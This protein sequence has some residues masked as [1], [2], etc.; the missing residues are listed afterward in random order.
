MKGPLAEALQQAATYFGAKRTW[1]LVNG[2]C[3]WCARSTY[4][5][6]YIR[7]N[8]KHYH[9]ID[10]AQEVSMLQS[11]RQCGCSGGDWTNRTGSKDWCCC[12][13]TRTSQPLEL[14]RWP[15]W[16]PSWFRVW[17]SRTSGCPWAAT[18]TPCRQPSSSTRV[19]Y[20]A[21][22]TYPTVS[23]RRKDRWFVHFFLLCTGG[24]CAHHQ[25]HLPG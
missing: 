3:A 11:W 18:W 23:I 8:L 5:R 2:R 12:L 17:W 6:S 14:Y 25:T 1:F 19:R 10:T 16:T 20:C 22:R 9:I 15:R 4:K 21:V 7:I 13:G 24:V